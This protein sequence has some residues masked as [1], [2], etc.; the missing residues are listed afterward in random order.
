MTRPVRRRLG[1]SARSTTGKPSPACSTRS[2][3][4]RLPS[5]NRLPGH[6][7]R[8][9]TRARWTRWCTRCRTRAAAFVSR[10]RGHSAPSATR[11][12]S[13]GCRPRSRIATP[14]FASRP[15]G[16]SAP[17]E[18]EG[19]S[20]TTVLQDLRLGVRLIRRSPGFTAIA[21][22]AL[23]I[24]IGANTAIFSVVNTLLLKRLPYR[25]PDR[26]AIVWEHNLPRDK[27]NNVVSPGNF[28]HWREMTLTFE[29]MAGVGMT[30]TQTLTG[31]GDPEELQMQF[32]TAAF[33][34]IVGVAPQIGRWV[35]PEEDAPNGPNVV[36]ISDRLWKR[37][38]QGD[39]AILR[40][41]IQL[42]GRSCTVV[43]V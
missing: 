35:T 37:R 31:V 30:F 22:A 4:P 41:P 20:M 36:V 38:F 1:R 27:K 26:L 9:T 16:R 5:A 40:N 34:P 17:S 43:G 33:F 2:R 12:R 29:D 10:P 8:S 11:A 15:P 14:G 6:S 23:A 39:P 13:E 18:S 25:D 32:I 7:V 24:G 28:L 21:V 42:Q 3:I 19:R